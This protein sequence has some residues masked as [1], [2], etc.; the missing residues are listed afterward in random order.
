MSSVIVNWGNYEEVLPE[1]HHGMFRRYA[2]APTYTGTN[3]EIW[4]NSET[5]R[6][7]PMSDLEMEMHGIKPYLR[8]THDLDNDMMDEDFAF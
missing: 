5:D 3:G 8:Q 7:E 6:L 2:N 1:K 4:Y